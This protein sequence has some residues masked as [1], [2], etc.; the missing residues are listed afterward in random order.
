MK[1]FPT[2]KKAEVASLL[3]RLYPDIPDK[4]Q[5]LEE[6][7]QRL[8]MDY[9]LDI[10]CRDIVEHIEAISQLREGSPVCVKS[11]MLRGNEWQVTIIGFDYIGEFSIITGILT[12]SKFNIKNGRVY[13][14][15][16][17][18]EER[19]IDIISR[20]NI[21]VDIFTV[22]LSLSEKADFKVIEYEFKRLIPLL[23]RGEMKRLREI[24]NSR[25]I[26]QFHLSGFRAENLVLPPVE[27]SIDNK[28]SER[29][30]I[31]NIDT[32]DTFGFLYSFSNA[33]AM[34]N[35][36]IHRVNISTSDDQITDQFFISDR[37][38]N[39]IISDKKIEDISVVCV[40]IKHFTHLLVVSPDPCRALTYFD[41][42]LDMV[43]SNKRYHYLWRED[44]M[45]ILARLFGSTQFLWEEF[46]RMQHRNIL[47]LLRDLHNIEDRKTKEKMQREL[48]LELTAAEE[49]DEKKGILN[50]YK[51]REMFRIDIRH[52][53]LSHD[54][55]EF[56]EELSDLAE[57]IM[58]STLDLTEDE[59]ISKY[60]HPEWKGEIAIMAAGKFGGREIGYASDLELLFI[61]P[62]SHASDDPNERASFFI[63]LTQLFNQTIKRKK[64][65]IF[66]IDLRLRPYGKDGPFACSEMS[67]NNYFNHEK[68]H[69]SPYERQ[70]LIK[71]R[72]V[73]GNKELGSRIESLRDSFVYADKD[74]S[75]DHLLHLR[76]R[77]IKELVS[78]GKINTKFSRGG[79]LDIEYFIQYLLLIYGKDIKELRTTRTLEALVLLRNFNIISEVSFQ[80]LYDAYI[81]LRHLIN[82]QRMFRGNAKDLVLPE[83]TSP[84]YRYL[85]RR[86]GYDDD[87][88][89][90]AVEKLD[91]DINLYMK[92]AERY[93]KEGLK[94]L[95]SVLIQ[96]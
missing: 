23:K 9:W 93:Y 66:E 17:M 87:S 60:G 79:L 77:Q 63:T 57:A 16:D 37:Q 24:V 59:M 31:L 19:G 50:Q 43:V 8:D 76:D 68:P 44:V 26:D 3:E 56:S 67:F 41:L 49:F 83:T 21:I 38:G 74:I 13:T 2:K 30:T 94:K 75:L 85:A 4:E 62:D 88:D 84:E 22:S 53:A 5:I 36:S 34:R 10:S 6:H 55:M 42:L 81:F 7:F 82:A 51:D 58:A 14:Y 39:K 73:A 86:M 61:Y 96:S 46:I 1:D 29:F 54:F 25:V 89:G 64:E 52:I 95:Q 45:L 92:N 32:K 12:Y 47:P 71:L 11:A 69:F 18:D 40:L 15:M 80:E 33:L 35:I 48:D 70:A 20:K 90:Y 78:G 91:R 27:I 28:S 65:G 72:Y